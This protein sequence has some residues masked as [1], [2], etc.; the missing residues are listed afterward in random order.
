M[1]TYEATRQRHVEYAMARLP[2][3]LE[4]LRWPAER[5]RSERTAQLRELLA[6][7]K[8]RAPWHARRL[9]RIDPAR[10]DEDRIGDLPTMT[11]NDLMQNFDEIVTDRRV[12]VARV[13]EH[14]AGLTS[15]AY[16]LDELHAVA[17]GGSS[18]VR[19]V[20]VWGWNAWANL[21]LAFA[22]RQIATRLHDAELA[23]RTPVAMMVAA[24]KASH[25]TNAVS[26]TFASPAA[27]LHSV[28]VTLPLSEI[29]AQLNRIDGDTLG[30]YASMLGTLAAEA[31]AGRLTVAP[32]RVFATSEPLLPEIRAAAEQAWGAPV[33]NVWGTSEGGI[34]ALSCYQDTGMHLCD[35][36]LIIE[37]VDAR[38]APVA[39]GTR[40]AKIFLTNLFNPE[41]PLIR[42]EISDEVVFLDEPCR[43]GSAHRRVADIQGRLD[44]VFRYAAGVVVHPHVFRSVLGRDAAISEYQVR[45]TRT[46]AEVAVRCCAPLDA[47]RLARELRDELRRLGVAGADANVVVVEQLERQ[48]TGK[49][50]RFVP[51]RTGP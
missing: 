18:G 32:Q 12:T 26:Q 46:G 7:A 39:P 24:G 36:L 9:A 47:E 1:T 35:D 23:G 48:D 16:L 29:V 22:R 28:P 30:A 15:D 40:S 49:L 14:I 6:I 25:M 37:A 43:C 34:T 5:L 10:I 50:K 31:R 44:D 33:G 27:E 21:Y 2:E 20:F 13:N 17:S 51:L 42:Y 19:G 8:A 41:L 11:K 3:H 4:R 45:Q 38:G